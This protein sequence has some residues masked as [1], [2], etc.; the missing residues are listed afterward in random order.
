MLTNIDEAGKHCVLLGTKKIVYDVQNRFGA[1]VI[2]FTSTTLVKNGSA[3]PLQIAYQPSTPPST[4]TAGASTSATSSNRQLLVLP[5]VAPG[6]TIPV[7]LE[8]VFEGALLFR[9]YTADEE[10]KY[11][12]S[13]TKC[14]CFSL[15]VDSRVITCA[16]RKDGLL[17][18][19]YTVH[20]E[21]TVADTGAYVCFCNLQRENTLQT[22]T[23]ILVPLH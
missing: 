19:Q 15:G 13:N 10:P 9:P 6:Q 1:K 11:R 2:S 23:H 14:E 3:H 8:M 17:P 4:T 16:P 12:W 21:N 20:V 7:P 22:L 18:F 5:P